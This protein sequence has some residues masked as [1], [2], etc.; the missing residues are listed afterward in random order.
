MTKT[1]SLKD[2]Q[3]DEVKDVIEL[4]PSSRVDS[5]KLDPLKIDRDKSKNIRTDYGDIDELS[6][7]IIAAKGV[8]EPLRVFIKGEGRINDYI[9]DP[10]NRFDLSHG[11]RRMDAIDLVIAKGFRQYVETVPVIILRKT[12]ESEVQEIFNHV[13]CN[14]SKPLTDMEFG[15]A[16]NKLINEHNMTPEKVAEKFRKTTAHVS[17][18]LNI[19]KATEKQPKI[20]QLIDEKKV[21][22]TLVGNVTKKEKDPKKIL[23]ILED[24]IKNA[25]AR[26]KDKATPQD[27]D[28]LKENKPSTAKTFK[29]AEKKAEEEKKNVQ[30]GGVTWT[31][32]DPDEVKKP[33]FD[34]VIVGKKDKVVFNPQADLKARIHNTSLEIFKQIVDHKMLADSTPEELAKKITEY[35]VEVLKAHT[36]PENLLLF[37][38]KKNKRNVPQGQKLVT[39]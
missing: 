14:K 37:A 33:N 3:K 19:Y 24:G 21:T 18:F 39:V 29:V 7:E 13:I 31:D 15:N 35:A 9:K 27:I 22:S 30:S 34:K 6:E 28:I 12:K 17:F 23:K 36:K 20:Q 16:Y 2:L 25:E 38:D 26:G 4:S 11:F 10:N 1:K 5:Y 32:E 8:Q